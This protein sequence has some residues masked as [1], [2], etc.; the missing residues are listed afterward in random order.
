M[1]KLRAQVSQFLLHL[2]GWAWH[3]LGSAAHLF[4]A[5][6]AG[7]V[8]ILCQLTVF[9]DEN[10]GRGAV[11]IMSVRWILP[12]ANDHLINVTFKGIWFRFKPIPMH[13]T[14]QQVTVELIVPTKYGEAY[15]LLPD[16]TVEDDQFPVS[17][18]ISICDLNFDE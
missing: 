2:R 9:P 17:P 11:R 4:Q 16:I 1:A 8:R 18:P 12:V 6:C 14:Y 10:R 7:A 15:Q 3:G 5:A 13:V